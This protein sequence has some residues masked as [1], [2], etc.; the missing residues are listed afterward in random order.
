MGT[1]IVEIIG[2]ETRDG[3]RNC[4]DYWNGD[5]RLAQE[6]W[7]LLDWRQEMGKGVVEFNGMETRDR[8]RYCGVY[9]DGDTRWTQVLWR[10]LEWRHEMGTGIMEI[11]DWRHEMG[12]GVV[13]FNGIETRDRHRYCR[14]YRDGD[15]R[16]AQVFWRLL[17]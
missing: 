8:H 15:T 13:E 7:R 16:W 1:G 17:E 5:T 12:K 6:L 14:V 3:H 10:L 4:G 2:M 11:M 9:R